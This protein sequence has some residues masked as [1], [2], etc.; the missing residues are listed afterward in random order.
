MTPP[1]T[2][3]ELLA[4]G[5]TVAAVAITGCGNSNDDAAPMSAPVS[6]HH[7]VAS[8]DPLHDRVILWTR[9]SDAFEATLV[10]WM[11]ATDPELS[12]VVRTNGDGV[13]NQPLY[14]SA[15]RDYTFKLDVS[16]L[17]PGTTYFYQFR[18]GDVASPIGRTRTAP[19]DALQLRFAVASCAKYHQAYW[20]AYRDIA[21]RSDLDLVLHCGDYI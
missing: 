9:I 2:R 20:H 19:V 4:A 5:T 1:I 3:R 11:V 13:D 21:A 15:E 18:V 6:F 14:A 16:G 7:G 8:G 10:S 12:S 17:Q